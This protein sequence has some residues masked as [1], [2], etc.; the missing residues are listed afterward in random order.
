VPFHG[1]ALRWPG[2]PANEIGPLRDFKMLHIAHPNRTNPP[3]PEAAYQSYASNYATKYPRLTS[4]PV[5]SKVN[6]GQKS[7]EKACD[8]HDF[9]VVPS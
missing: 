9:Q 3:R 8:Q 5:L 2:Q 4:T 7:Y 1:L 6:F